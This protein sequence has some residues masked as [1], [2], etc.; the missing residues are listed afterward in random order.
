MRRR[1]RLDTTHR[2]IRDGLIAAGWDVLSLAAMGAGVA[3]FVVH[4]RGFMAF[5]DA[6]SPKR[7]RK[8]AEQLTEAQRT[9][10]QRWPV[11]FAET[12]EEALLGLNA[13]RARRFVA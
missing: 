7:V 4:Q 6:K 1:P 11:V 10:A 13:L 5:V 9:F 8:R 2:A 3:D 12:V